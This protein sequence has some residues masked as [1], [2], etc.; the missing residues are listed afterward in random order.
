M[1]KKFNLKHELLLVLTKFIALAIVAL[2][3][4]VAVYYCTHI[5]Y[6]REEALHD[7]FVCTNEVLK[8]GDV[9]TWLTNGTLLGAVRLGHFVMWDGEIDIAVL[10]EGGS[11]IDT[12]IETIQASC[13]PYSN[14]LRSSGDDGMPRRWHMCTRRVCAEIHEFLP[15]P[16]APGYLRSVDGLTPTSQVFSLSPCLIEGVNASC[17][18]NA[19]YFLDSAY[20]PEWRSGSLTAMFF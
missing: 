2:A 10:N 8:S 5:Y 19:T 3:G 13:F 16:E 17:P 6:D 15:A 14:T 20:G 11:S 4:T 9:V 12:A 7:A 1:P 18:Q